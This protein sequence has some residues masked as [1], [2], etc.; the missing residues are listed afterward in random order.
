[1]EEEIKVVTRQE[2][3]NDLAVRELAKGKA[4]CLCRIQFKRC[5]LDKCTT[6]DRHKRLMNCKAAMSDF[7]IERLNHYTNVYYMEYSMNPMAWMSHK[8]YKR[9][10]AKLF[11]AVI[12]FLFL[13]LFIP[14]IF[15]GPLDAPINTVDYDTVIIKVIQQAQSQVYDLDGDNK[16]NCI[17]YAVMFKI[18]WDR[19]YPRLSSHCTIVRN[20]NW[21]T[22]MNHLFIFVQDDTGMNI[23]VEPGTFDP[24][25]YKMEEVWEDKYDPLYNNY[26]ETKYW[27]SEVK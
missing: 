5:K 18:V 3:F 9:H 7:D 11:F 27:L 15:I 25:I 2:T 10:F 13:L 23:A 21:K 4:S 20:V 1:M 16:V 19:N 17:D 14:A 12:L 6:C 8:E 24:E 22:G 26:G